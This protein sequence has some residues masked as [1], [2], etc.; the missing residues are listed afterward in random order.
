MNDDRETDRNEA[1][2]P[3]DRNGTTCFWVAAWAVTFTLPYLFDT[4]PSLSG[5]Q[6]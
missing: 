3:L 4:E 6:V 2:A 5:L 1:E